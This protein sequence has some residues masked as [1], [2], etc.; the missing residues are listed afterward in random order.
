MDPRGHRLRKRNPK[1]V[2]RER[3]RVP[4]SPLPTAVAY[5]LSHKIP[6]S[7][8]NLV[9][10]WGTKRFSGSVYGADITHRYSANLANIYSTQ[11][12]PPSPSLRAIEWL[13]DE[14]ARLPILIFLFDRVQKIAVNFPNKANLSN[15]PLFCLT[16]NRP[17]A[18][19]LITVFS[20]RMTWQTTTLSHHCSKF[21]SLRVANIDCGAVHFS[22]KVLSH[23]DHIVSRESQCCGGKI[24]QFIS[25]LPRAGNGVVRRLVDE[26]LQ[27]LGLGDAV[28][29]DL[30]SS[31]PSNHELIPGSVGS[32]GTPFECSCDG[33]RPSNVMRLS[34]SSAASAA[35]LASLGNVES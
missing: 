1:K 32:L 16:L 27:N 33:A 10:T 8:A 12:Q 3:T 7:W 11:I 6:Q 29:I 24:K 5:S 15:R 2:T 30:S 9:L 23:L 14:K 19:F 4:S 25:L 28:D 20:I 13:S 18:K 34:D 17:P 21:P 22:N 26:V 35:A 31:A